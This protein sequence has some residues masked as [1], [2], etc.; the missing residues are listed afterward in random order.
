MITV[1]VKTATVRGR[2]VSADITNTPKEVLSEVGVNLSG[3]MVN[4][5]GMQLSA[6][7][8]NQ[9]FETLGIADG[10]TTNLTAVKKADGAIA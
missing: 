1:I 4:L 9:T 8:M 6:A 5:D 2:N 7:D 10:T 3:E